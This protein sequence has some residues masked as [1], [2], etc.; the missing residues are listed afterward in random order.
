MES[1]ARV[2]KLGYAS[3]ALNS[4]VQHASVKGIREGDAVTVQRNTAT[5]LT[6]CEILL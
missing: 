3:S 5:A 4:N 1:V 2:L 6:S